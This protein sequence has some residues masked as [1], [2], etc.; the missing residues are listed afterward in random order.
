MTPEEIKTAKAV[1]EAAIV[2]RGF[3]VL[4]SVAHPEIKVVQA[5]SVE[6]FPNTMGH[7]KVIAEIR[8]GVLTVEE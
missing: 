7:P 5:F 8:N 3:T 1:V 6:V 4:S 2:D